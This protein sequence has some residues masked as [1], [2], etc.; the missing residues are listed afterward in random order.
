M[1]EAKLTEALEG[2]VAHRLLPDGSYMAVWKMAAWV[3][4]LTWSKP[5][6]WSGYDVGY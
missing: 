6:N 1:V 4:R 2:A 5:G 3:T